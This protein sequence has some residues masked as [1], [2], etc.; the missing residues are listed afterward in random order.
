MRLEDIG[1]GQFVKVPDKAELDVIK[2]VNRFF[3]SDITEDFERSKEAIILESQK[4]LK[5]LVVNLVKRIAW[6]QGESIYEPIIE[7]LVSV[8][9]KDQ[10]DSIIAALQNQLIENYTFE[11]NIT[12]DTTVKVEFP[13]AKPVSMVTD[14]IKVRVN[15]MQQSEGINYDI[16]GTADTAQFILFKEALENGDCVEVECWL[17][18]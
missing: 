8:A 4:R 2:T 1:N 17:Y 3:N 7:N 11:E 14:V 18:S 9:I 15:G 10:I 5:P 16:V 6:E 12:N 13:A